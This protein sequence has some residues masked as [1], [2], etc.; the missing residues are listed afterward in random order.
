[1]HRLLVTG[2]TGFLGAPCVRLASGGYEVHA[3]GRGPGRGVPSGVHFHHCDLLA[4]RAATRL[5]EGVRPTH[6]LHLAWVVTPGACWESPE[7]H[8]W[9]AASQELLLAFARCSGSRAVVAGSCA[10]Y[11][12]SG[13]SG[14]CR[15]GETPTHPSTAY[16]RCKLALSEW[17]GS[18]ARERGISLAWPRLFWLYG[19]GEHPAR[20]VPAVALGLLAGE[21]VPCTSGTQI[22][23]F[24]HVNDAAAALVALLDSTATGPL[25]VG[26]GVPVAVGDI[27]RAV[28][29]ACGRPD[30]VR[31]GERP[32]PAHEPLAVVADTTQLRAATDW[33]PNTPLAAGIAATVEWWKSTRAA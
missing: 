21:P 23:D 22:R 28:A 31:L 9:V 19:P 32:T 10:E 14:A 11:D 15:E 25:N 8:R 24:I 13:A 20:L 4:P 6:L 5:I 1:M 29:L 33:R 16:G 27:V 26:S 17:A 18:F 7:N 2:S 3:A 30:L 12:W